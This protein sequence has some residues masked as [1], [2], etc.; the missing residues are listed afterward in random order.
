MKLRK[1][2]YGYKTE[3]GRFTIDR[4]YGGYEI[5][6]HERVEEYTPYYGKVLTRNVIRWFHTLRQCREYI[7]K[8]L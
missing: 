4:C 2:F 7:E 1:T 3:D 5:K 6:D 8:N